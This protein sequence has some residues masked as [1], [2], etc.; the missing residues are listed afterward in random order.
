M[1]VRS[2]RAVFELERRVYRIDTIRLNPGG[3]PLR[4]I[5]YAAAA[6]VMSLVAGRLPPVRLILGP[7]PWYVRYLG[8][9]IGLAA[10]AAIARIDGRPFHLAAWAL[11]AWA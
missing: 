4:G 5:V 1:D 9:P 8:L 11:A 3:V 2:Y 10:V 7:L 6:V